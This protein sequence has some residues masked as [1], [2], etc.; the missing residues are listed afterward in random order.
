MIL[1]VAEQ[2]FEAVQVIPGIIQIAARQGALHQQ[3]QALQLLLRLEG[4]KHLNA[5]TS[6][7]FGLIQTRPG[8]Q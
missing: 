2:V 6:R 1:A 5:V 8:P 3:G 4:G 7:R